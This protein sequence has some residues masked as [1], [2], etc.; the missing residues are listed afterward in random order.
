MLKRIVFLLHSAGL[1]FPR[2]SCLA[3]RKPV[4]PCA[5]VYERVFRW[6]RHLL[7]EKALLRLQIVFDG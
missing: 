2:L 3:V 5:S 7:P 1:S 6:Q 4:N